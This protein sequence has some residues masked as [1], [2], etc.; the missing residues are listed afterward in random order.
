MPTWSTE[1]IHGIIA[2][3]N[4]WSLRA[5]LN[6]LTDNTKSLQCHNDTYYYHCYGGQSAANRK[7]KMVITSSPRRVS[8]NRGKMYLILYSGKLSWGPNFVLCYLQLIR[9]FNFHS[10]H[11]TQEDTP[12]IIYVLCVKFSLIDWERKERNLDPTKISCY[13]V[14]HLGVA[15]INTTGLNRWVTM[16]VN[17]ETSIGPCTT[18]C[19]QKPWQTDGVTEEHQNVPST[20]PHSLPHSNTTSYRS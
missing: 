20:D 10:V 5:F 3:A 13:T 19:K 1:C 8:A 14:W 6:T 7:T 4:L 15:G 11:F 16:K 2:L 17:N 12:I 18:C 9:V